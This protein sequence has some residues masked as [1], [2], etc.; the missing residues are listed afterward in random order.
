MIANKVEGI[1]AGVC[2]DVYSAERLRKSND[3]QILTLGARVIGVE[4]AKCVITAWMQSE[5]EA[6]RSLPK[7]PGCMSWNKRIARGTPCCPIRNS[8]AASLQAGR[9]P[10][11]AWPR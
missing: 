8:I 10:P 1:Y 9:H 11:A 5:F 3:A 7:S 2:H 6:G 4:A